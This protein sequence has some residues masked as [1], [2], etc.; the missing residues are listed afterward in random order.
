MK[1][2][3]VGGGLAGLSL[4][5]YCTLNQLDFKLITTKNNVS[6]VVAAGMINPLVFRRLNLSWKVNVYLPE[7]LQFYDYHS[8]LF[9]FKVYNPLEIRRFFA[10]EQELNYWKKKQELADYQ[11]F[12]H[13]LSDEDLH[14]PSKFNTFGTGRVKQAGYVASAP[15]IEACWD[16]YSQSGH[17]SEEHFDWNFFNPSLKTYKNEVYDC[18]VFAEGKDGKY[19]PLFNY[20]P[21]NQTKGELLTVRLTSIAPDVSI[22]RK[23]FTLPLG[24]GTFRIGSTYVWNTDNTEI[25]EEGK[26]TIL[27]NLASVTDEIPE[28]LE[29]V[30]GVRPTVEDRRPLI[31]EHPNYKGI[32]F[33]NG[34][35]THGYTLAPSMAKGLLE[36]IL[37]G[38]PLDVE[39]DIKRYRHL[40][41]E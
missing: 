10:S 24:D 32:Y 12:L 22:N 36:H 1:I 19:N 28:V 26:A 29:Q 21:L 34:L 39:V 40:L 23:C 11:S 7:A 14:F 35:G 41:Q 2:L 15:F 3:I 13:P 25:T 30:A 37:K 4:A 38:S 33:Y 5:H 27:A 6:S 20:L 8:N 18:I 16:Y 17:L 9:Q 31:G